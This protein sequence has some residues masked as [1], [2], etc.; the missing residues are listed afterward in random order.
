MTEKSCLDCRSE[1]V[2][3]NDNKKIKF[4]RLD[5]LPFTYSHSNYNIPVTKAR[6]GFDKN[7]VI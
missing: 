7:E 6:S 2:Y 1:G 3:W 4:P 5:S